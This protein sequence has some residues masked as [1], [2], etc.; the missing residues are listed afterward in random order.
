M[1]SWPSTVGAFDGD[2]D[3]AGADEPGIVA[4]ARRIGRTHKLQQFIE[5]HKFV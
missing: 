2:E 1:K 4:Q 3:I 5:S